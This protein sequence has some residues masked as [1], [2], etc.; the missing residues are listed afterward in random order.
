MVKAKVARMAPFGAF[1]EIEEGIEG[2]C[3]TSEF[4]DKKGSES[5]GKLEIGSEH[6]FRVIR[7]DPADRKISLSLKPLAAPP[8][9]PKIN[10]R[11]ESGSGKPSFAAASAES[12][13]KLEP[14]TTTTMAEALSAAG[15]TPRRPAPEAP[16]VKAP[17]KAAPI[18]EPTP[19][20]PAV[21]AAPEAAVAVEPA[22][23]QVDAVAETKPMA[24]V[25]VAAPAVTVDQTAAETPV[26]A[27][28]S[29][30]VVKTEEKAIVAGEGDPS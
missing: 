8:P 18:E 6:E 13:K 4:G 9:P 14:T 21:Q 12:K 1:V 28:A 7:L 25:E 16:V 19:A 2:L 22:V 29:E 30:P 3:H 11:A 24:V 10:K 26:A 27:E 5:K 23:P 15:I 20:A 17:K